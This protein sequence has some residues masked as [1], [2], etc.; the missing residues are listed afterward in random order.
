MDLLDLVFPERLYCMACE[1][2]ISKGEED[3]LCPKCRGK[4]EWII[5]NPR[6]RDMHLFSFDRLWT[7]TTYGHLPRDIVMKMKKGRR[8]QI[9]RSV[10]RLLAD[11][12][13]LEELNGDEIFTGVPMH[14]DKEMT[15]GYNQAELLAKYCAAELGAIYRRG[16]LLKLQDTASM[17]LASGDERRIMLQSAFSCREKLNGENI[18]LVDDVITTGSTADACAK[19]L[20]EAGAG[21]VTVLCFAATKSEGL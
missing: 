4:M 17:R 12:V 20:K 6:Q 15:R 2:F 13:R 1:D 10:G 9:A 3:G 8:P 5:D 11:R 16:L 7:C 21:S 14:R 18:I 19:C